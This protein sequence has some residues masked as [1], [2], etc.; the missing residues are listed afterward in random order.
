LLQR[1]CYVLA[2]SIDGRDSH[3]SVE[4]L[5]LDRLTPWYQ[6]RRRAGTWPEP[7]ASG[8]AGLSLYRRADA[9]YLL[10]VVESDRTGARIRRDLE[11]VVLQ[12]GLS[13]SELGSAL[14]GLLAQPEQSPIGPDPRRLPILR[15]A[16]A[17]SWR[18]FIRGAECVDVSRF[19]HLYTVHPWIRD[20]SRL[21]GYQIP[22]HDGHAGLDH[23]T[24]TQLG[25]A[26]I[27]AC[28]LVKD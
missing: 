11:P 4:Y 8:I 19:G 9:Y 23:P 14:I 24:A 15:V 22:P 10:P 17:P 20:V 5:T 3:G 27:R 16:K 2:M 6:Q 12:L 13:A 7:G 26:V 18:Q 1:R 25:T 21:D 28:D